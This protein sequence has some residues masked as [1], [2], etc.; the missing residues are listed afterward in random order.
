[1]N[2]NK[3]IFLTDED[4]KQI[5]LELQKKRMK[6]MQFEEKSLWE[7]PYADDIVDIDNINEG[8]RSSDFHGSSLIISTFTSPLIACFLVKN[9]RPG[10]LTPIHV[11]RKLPGTFIGLYILL[12]SKYMFNLH[13]QPQNKGF[14]ETISEEELM[15]KILQEK[16][17]MYDSI[18]AILNLKEKYSQFELNQLKKEET[19]R[20]SVIIR[21]NMR[22]LSNLMH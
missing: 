21:E 8:F 9:N 12:S 15:Y 5:S 14:F 6:N 11:L 2:S 20:N 16:T 1:M 3:K 13:S 17:D 18:D 10:Q 7:L 22:N 4:F 19:E